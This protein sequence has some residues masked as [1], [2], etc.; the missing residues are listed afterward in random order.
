MLLRE[1]HGFQ[2]R[3][4]KVE[5]CSSPC[6]LNEFREIV[7]DVIPEDWRRECQAGH[8]QPQVA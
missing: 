2:T 4:V 8:V 3:V 5:G 7:K 1:G 6:P